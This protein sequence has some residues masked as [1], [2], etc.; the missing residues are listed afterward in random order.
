[1]TELN[2]LRV[3]FD[4]AHLYYLPQYLPICHEL[5]RR[6]AAC[7]LVVYTDEE[8]SA[9]LK[10]AI[11]DT[12]LPSHWVAS[13]NEALAYYTR[14]RPDWVVFGNS[15]GPLDEMPASVRTAMVNHGAGVKVAGYSNQMN[16]MTVRFAEG[17]HHFEALREDFPDRRFVLAGFPKLDPIINGEQPALDLAAL[18]L[19]PGKPTLLYAPTFYPSSIENMADTWP[20]QLPEFNILVKLHFFSY[21]N[22]R[23]RHQLKKAQRWDRHPNASLAPLADYSLSPYLQTAGLLISDASTA[24]FEAAAL[25]KPVVWCDFVK[26]R[27]NYRG[28]F[29]YRYRR[30]MDPRMQQYYDIARH[31]ARYRDLNA[32]I[33]E[34]HESPG[35][36]AA[37]RKAYSDQLLG[38][39]DG[40]AAVRIV[41]YLCGADT[42]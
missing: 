33:R 34:Q 30:R 32:A 41:D 1:V 4:I 42:S 6:G 23:Y 38:P 7:E 20:A 29:R 11:V 36:F 18:G 31:V 19:D 9:I 28:P 10:Q 21:I 26:L 13:E 14:S 3:A 16:R 17:A 2:A 5:Q 12:G 37:K 27:W 24:L 39:C 40:R 15:F 35:M 22:K 25:D 8:R